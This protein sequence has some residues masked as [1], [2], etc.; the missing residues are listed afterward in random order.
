MQ[1]TFW[2]SRVQ[3]FSIW[4]RNGTSL[5]LISLEEARSNSISGVQTSK[6]GRMFLRDKRKR[7]GLYLNGWICLLRPVHPSV[8]GSRVSNVRGRR[9]RKVTCRATYITQSYP[10]PLNRPC[11]KIVLQYY[12][13][14]R[15]ARETGA[16][17]LGASR[18]IIRIEN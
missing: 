1:F 12:K 16:V 2:Y 3:K 9:G 14:S 18:G 15:K 6:K 8:L 13:Y 17:N 4:E 10:Q 11:L 5:A 7:K